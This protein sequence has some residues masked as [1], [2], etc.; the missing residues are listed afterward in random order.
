MEDPVPLEICPWWSGI[1]DVI[2]EVT[3]NVEATTY[4]EKAKQTMLIFRVVG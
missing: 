2:E 4:E 1:Y 3:E